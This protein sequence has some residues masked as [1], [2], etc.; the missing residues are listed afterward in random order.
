MARKTKI[1]CFFCNYE[2]LNN[3]F[4]L[5]KYKNT[6]KKVCYGCS[7][8]SHKACKS[9]NTGCFIDCS[10]CSNPVVHNNCLKCDICNHMVH[11]KCNNLSP[12]DI[13]PIE[14]H[15][16]FICKICNEQIFPFYNFDILKPVIKKKP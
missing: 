8:S 11:A 1:T 15:K 13:K 7:P 6:F 10:V 2:I 4:R 9:S 16:S 5:L 3:K 12:N 14:K